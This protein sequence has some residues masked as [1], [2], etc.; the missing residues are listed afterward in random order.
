V[1]LVLVLIFVEIVDDVGDRQ[2]MLENVD[3][4]VDDAVSS[5][6]CKWPKLSPPVLHFNTKTLIDSTSDAVTSTSGLL[7]DAANSGVVG[8]V[9]SREAR[10][11][12]GMLWL[13]S[14][15]KYAFVYGSN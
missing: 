3:R 4:V 8:T 7:S 5:T 11:V 14:C 9:T 1:V 2:L 12:V 15:S 6:D 13:C 10:S